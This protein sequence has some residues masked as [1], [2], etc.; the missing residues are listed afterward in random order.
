MK[1]CYPYVTVLGP[2]V[3]AWGYIG[4]GMDRIPVL[5]KFIVYWERKN[6]SVIFLSEKRHCQK[7]WQCQSQTIVF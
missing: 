7:K 3:G 1:I 5:M 6:G 4:K 2:G